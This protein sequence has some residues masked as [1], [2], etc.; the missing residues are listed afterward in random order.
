MNLDT[1]AVMCSVS[2]VEANR[3]AGFLKMLILVVGFVVRRF[4]LCKEALQIQ[5]TY[6]PQSIYDYNYI[7]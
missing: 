2:F 3:P 4:I 7:L 6:M 1:Y 5:Y